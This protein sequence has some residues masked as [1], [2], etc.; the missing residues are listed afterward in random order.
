M[1]PHPD[2]VARMLVSYYYWRK[3]DLSQLDKMAAPLTAVGGHLELFADSGAFSAYTQRGGGAA[4]RREEYAAWLTEWQPRLRVMVNLDVIGDAAGS[5]RNQLWLENRGLNVTPVYHMQSP[6][7]ELEA[8]CRDY[9]YICVGGTA[10]LTGAQKT[11]ATARAMIVAREHGTAVHGL[12]RSSADELSAIGFY[13]VDSTT[14]MQAARYGD[15]HLFDGR[16]LRRLPIRKAVSEPALIRRHGG[17]PQRMCR[18]DYANLQYRN[19]KDPAQYASY[20]RENDE[21]VFIAGVAWKRFEAHLRRRHQV[22]P[23]PG[24]ETNGTNVWFADDNMLHQQQMIAAVAWLASS[25]LRPGANW[26]GKR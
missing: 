12:G 10:S 13:S 5:A 18:P 22:P 7:A 21:V 20:R 16:T 2:P 26:E 9:R 15:I 14:W 8:L 3:R 1:T 11:A 25:P 6:V 17:D 24:H 19:R 4:I 23:P